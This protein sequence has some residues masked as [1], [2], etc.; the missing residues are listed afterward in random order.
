MQYLGP[1]D[2]LTLISMMVN[3]TDNH[4]A[5]ELGKSRRALHRYRN[6][7]S[8]KVHNTLLEYLEEEATYAQDIDKEWSVFIRTRLKMWRSNTYLKEKGMIK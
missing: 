8:L 6:K 4:L 3:N 1:T 2:P 7:P 5:D